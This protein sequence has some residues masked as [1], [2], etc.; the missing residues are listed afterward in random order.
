MTTSAL[1]KFSVITVSYNQGE[2]IRD[3]IESVLAQNYPNFEHI[4]VDAG[5]TDATL[6][7]LKEYPHIKWTSEPD[8]GQSHGLNKGFSRAT[9]DI[10]AWI[11]SDD[12]YAPGT[13]HEVATM[14]QHSP[15]VM[16]GCVVTDRVGNP[17]EEVP[18]LPRD[19]FDTLK[20]WVYHSIPTQPGIFFARSIFSDL[21]IDPSHALDEGLE[22]TMDYDLW[23][24][25][26]ERYPLT[27][28]STKT[29]AYVR[30][31]E[32]NKTGAF[33]ASAYRE[34]SRVFR[35]HSSRRFP[36]EQAVSVVV[37]VGN[38]ALN[39]Q[40]IAERLAEQSIKQVELLCID[41]SG[42][43]E[44]LKALRREL[45]E[46]EPRFPS[47]TFRCQRITSVSEAPRVE[48]IDFGI[49]SSASPL[50]AVVEDANVIT[51]D[52]VTEILRIFAHDS[53]GF[54]F[55]GMKDGE[56]DLL[57]T[58]A[59]HGYMF[60]P[61]GVLQSTLRARQF[62]VRKVAWFDCGGFSAQEPL[63]VVESYCTKRLLLQLVHKAWQIMFST[64]GNGAERMAQES[65]S[66]EMSLRLYENCSI[67]DEIGKD[68]QIN[69][70]TSLRQKNGFAL[71][72]PESLFQLAQGVLATLPQN[73]KEISAVKEIA[74][75]R[76]VVEQH[77]SNG[78]L[79]MRLITELRDAG[80]T[81]EAEE[82][83]KAWKT[84]HEWEKQCPLY[85]A[86]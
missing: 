68:A 29:F 72:L 59:E 17:T 9:G 74:E 7:I 47:L 51:P 28:R 48:A 30:V 82:H 58:R 38:E 42:S 76:R 24:R 69:L 5:S 61:V 86:R 26:Q 85:G 78:P 64:S 54:V 11:N 53:V 46:L 34:M 15:V 50:I 4:V 35:R 62:I 60:N 45:R 31:Y 73:F 70:F 1:P 13:F 63:S 10:I 81:A 37:P 27:V 8:R 80:A 67:V 33:M 49:R 52:F 39:L 43:R 21:N 14:M 2:F 22:Y 23:M 40:L 84:I 55:W 77:P 41:Y 32:T 56:R 66:K 12:W 71:T 18:N 36:S 16:G 57:F 25:I 65:P 19:W 3:T 20:Y 44:R 6:S 83:F 79:R 75:L